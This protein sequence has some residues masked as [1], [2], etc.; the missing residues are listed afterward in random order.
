L[1]NLAI[2]NQKLKYEEEFAAADLPGYNVGKL[3]TK[4]A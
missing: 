3:R 4:G 2:V 1:C